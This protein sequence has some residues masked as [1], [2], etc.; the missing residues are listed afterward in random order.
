MIKSTEDFVAFGQ[1]NL[2]AFV[3]SGKIWAAG[4]QDLT[5]QF[6]TTAKASFDE[7]VTNLKAVSTA[8]SIKE[9]IDMQSTSPDHARKGDGLNRT[10]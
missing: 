4:I 7:S 9:A 1:A 3:T 6:T 10:S 5:K 8:K 2:E